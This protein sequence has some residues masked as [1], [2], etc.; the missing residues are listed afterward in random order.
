MGSKKDSEKHAEKQVEKHAEKH[1]EK[2]MKSPRAKSSVRNTVPGVQLYENRELSWL[3]FNERVLEESEDERTPLCERLSFISIFQTNLD[4]FFMVRVGSIHDEMMLKDGSRENKTGMTMGEQ[5]EAIRERVKELNKRKDASYA[6]LMGRLQEENIHIINFQKLDE[7]QGAYLQTYFEQEV[8]PLLS[9]II[10]TK[11]QPF[12]FIKNNEICAVAVL[13]TKNSKA[14]KVNTRIGIVPCNNGMFKRLI[15]I[16]GSAGY[17]M[18]AEELILHFLP[19]V[20]TGYNIV[21]KSLIRVTRNADIDA[22]KGYDEEL[23]YREHMEEIIKQRRKLTPV[24]MEYTRDL[25]KQ[26]LM[27][28][29]NY[30]KIDKDMIFKIKAPLDLSFVFDIQDILRNKSELF[31]ERRIPQRSPELDETKPLLPQIVEKDKFLSYPYQSIRPFLNMLTEAAN[32]PTVVSIKMTL[33]R[34]AKQSKV[35]EAL[36]EAAENGKQVDVLV[37]LKARFDEENNIGWSRRL[38]AAGCHVIYG[39]DGLKVHSKLCLITR[40][41]GDEVQYITQIG[42]GNYNEKTARLYTDLCIMTADEKIGAEAARVFQALSLGEVMQST[43]H[44]FVAPKCLQNKIID[45]IERE[46]QIARDGGEG[47]L[48]F[49]L[50]SL[51]DKVIIDKLIEASEAGVKI[52]MIIRGINCLRT[53][54]PGKTDNIRVVSIVG[55]FLEHSRIYIFGKGNREEIYIASADFMTRNTVHRV[56]VAAPVYD[57]DSRKKIMDMFRLQLRDNV[58]AR[59]QQPDGSYT[60]VLHETPAVNAQEELYLEAY[61]AAGNVVSEQGAGAPAAEETEV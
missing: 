24:R 3:R 47:Y 11:K 33:Y 55:R 32:D 57:P 34:L 2:Q 35:V 58:K 31:F 61:Q 16:P 44:L 48:G 26:V 12:P 40:K 59:E 42:T 54:I 60:Y 7:R 15:Q 10:V 51:T 45:K 50:N 25:D 28:M 14:K 1:T 8:M 49:K 21:S 17:Y 18:L 6:H 13:G 20:F 29:K 30:L 37:E 22:D 4:E 23:S 41:V 52:E 46:I 39:L 38:E 5:L 19:S 43:E 53:G 36:V 56:E 27:Q 9:P